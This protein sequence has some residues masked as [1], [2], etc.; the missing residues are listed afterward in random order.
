MGNPQNFGIDIPRRCH[1]LLDKLWPSVSKGGEGRGLPL[2][3]SFLLAISTP[4]VNL[5][6][7]RIWKPQNG[8]SVGHINDSVLDG[9]LARAIKKEIGQNELSQAVFFQKNSWRYRF[10]PKGDALPDL[11]KHG[12]PNEVHLALKTDLAL[13]DAASL[14]TATFCGILRNGLAHGGILYLDANGQTTE[15]QP[16]QKFCFVSTKLHS[17]TRAVVGL[18]FLQI[19]MKDYRSFLA[20]W[21][22]WLQKASMPSLATAK[23]T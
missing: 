1:I 4:M 18:H 20:L 11:S 3:A 19:G 7:E 10:L 22:D 23:K 13:A 15:G 9:S 17:K 2:N 12:L 21:A 8:G 6:I 14:A 5:P 16:V